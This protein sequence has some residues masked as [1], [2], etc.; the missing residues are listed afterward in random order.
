MGKE[1]RAAEIKRTERNIRIARETWHRNQ[2]R[3]NGDHLTNLLNYRAT[4]EES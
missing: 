4:L 2:C 1:Q 3:M